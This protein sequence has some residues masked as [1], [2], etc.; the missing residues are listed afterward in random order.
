MELIVIPVM[1]GALTLKGQ[2]R[3]EEE[4]KKAGGKIFVLTGGPRSLHVNPGLFS[5]LCSI[6]VSGCLSVWT[7][8]ALCYEGLALF[9]PAIMISL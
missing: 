7:R 3:E 6:H 4:K 9:S 1:A 8:N 5:L 2:E